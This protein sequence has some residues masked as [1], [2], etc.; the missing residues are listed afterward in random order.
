MAN[1]AWAM[2]GISGATFLVTVIGVF[3][4]WRTLGA[5]VATLREAERT[6]KAAEKTTKA[7]NRQAK[8]ARRIGEAQVRAYV[9]ITEATVM[10][11]EGLINV[12]PKFTIHAKNSGNSP[13][14]SFRWSVRV[15]YHP[16]GGFGEVLGS[17]MLDPKRAGKDIPA[18]DVV[19][20]TK[21]VREAAPTAEQ[22]REALLRIQVEVRF[23]YYDTFNA[24]HHET[25]RFDGALFGGNTGTE[26]E[27]TL[28]S[29]TADWMPP[30]QASK[31]NAGS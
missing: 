29:Y 12:A 15:R 22:L 9:Q 25:H 16:A 18:N 6:T 28:A 1:A 10:M 19:V 21:R 20:F 8:I 11:Q 17:G 14:L 27:L 3:L 2:F 30:R 31:Q 5:T 26:N 24:R 23:A 4:L 13:A 7:A